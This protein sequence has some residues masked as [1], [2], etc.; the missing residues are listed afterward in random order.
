MKTWP[1]TWELVEEYEGN[2]IF[3]NELKEFQVAIDN[4]GAFNPRYC[5][6]FQQLSGTFV[7]IGFEDG[8]YST[9]AFDQEEALSKAIKMM[10]F[11]NSKQLFI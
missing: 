9:H 6:N 7:K 3:E 8:A 5:I 11:I 1:K 4:M 10:E 2:F